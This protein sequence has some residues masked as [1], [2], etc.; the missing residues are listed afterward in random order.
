MKIFLNQLK[1]GYHMD[2]DPEQYISAQHQ[3]LDSFGTSEQRQF[4]IDT[5]SA[6]QEFSLV[7]EIAVDALYGRYDMLNSK[8]MCVTFLVYL[9]IF[10][11]ESRHTVLGLS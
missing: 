11:F 6:V 10:E 1:D 2:I 9:I 7:L 4:L 3:I 5:F 8:R